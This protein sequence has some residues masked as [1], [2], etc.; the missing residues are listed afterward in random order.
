MKLSVVLRRRRRTKR[1]ATA[2][3]EAVWTRWT[4]RCR[5]WRRP[6]AEWADNQSI[7]T[8]DR[9]RQRTFAAAWPGGR[10][11]AWCP[12]DWPVGS[13]PAKRWAF[14]VG[15]R[16]SVRGRRRTMGTWVSIAVDGLWRW[17]GANCDGDGLVVAA[18]AGDGD[19]EPTYCCY[20]CC[21]SHS[22]GVAKG[23]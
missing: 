8:V 11:R 6:A 14:A 23:I 13:G 19:D 3:T 16:A 17:N 5:G 15:G 1:V 12:G 10:G 7:A 18:G 9:V 21:L 4:T 20:C 2:G 22:S